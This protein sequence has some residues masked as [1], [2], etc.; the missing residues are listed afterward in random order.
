MRQHRILFERVFELAGSATFGSGI[1]VYLAR[2][3]CA[4]LGRRKIRVIA[5]ECTERERLTETTLKGKRSG[6]VAN[7]VTNDSERVV[8]AVVLITGTVLPP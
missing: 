5:P 1:G 8:D 7:K 6:V 3:L 4:S 2:V